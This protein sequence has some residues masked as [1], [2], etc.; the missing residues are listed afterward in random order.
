MKG[1]YEITIKNRR[2]QYKFKIVRNI[3]I[4]KGDSA[5]G[6]TTLIEMISAYQTTREKSGIQL[7]C[8]KPCVVLTDQNWQLNLSQIKDSIIFIDEGSSFVMSKNFYGNIKNTSNYYVIVTRTNLYN[9]PYSIK[10]IYGIKNTSQNKYQGTKQIYNEFYPIYDK[11][12]L[13]IQKPDLIIVEDSKAGYE[14]FSELCKKHSISCITANGKS[15]I[16]KKLL[17]VTEENILVI[18]D[19]AAFGSEIENILEMTH[20]K[21]LGIY[22]PESFEWLLLKANLLKDIDT[23]NILKNPSD[24]IESSE[25]FSWETF[26][27]KLITDK[28]HGTYLSY[29]K[30]SLNSSYLQDKESNAIMKIF[31]SNLQNLFGEK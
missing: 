16:Y 9:L 28:T 20:I 8:K 30:N 21:N 7:T 1:S 25:Y 14:F 19:G 2:I 29:S 3:T 11:I 15:N 22:L 12:T 13:K 24:Y 18:A 31:P 10:E 6:K 4:L 5:T 23:E 26:F 27:T 17:T